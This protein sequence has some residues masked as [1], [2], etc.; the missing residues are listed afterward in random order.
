MEKTKNGPYLPIRSR[1]LISLGFSWA[2]SLQDS[3]E[4]RAFLVV[5]M[6]KNLPAMQETWVWSLS[7]ED[8]LEKGMAT[9]SSILACR[10]TQM[11]EPGGLQSTGSQRVGSNWPICQLSEYSFYKR[12]SLAVHFLYPASYGLDCADV[13]WT[14]FNH[15]GELCF[16]GDGRT[17]W[18]GESG[19]Q[20]AWWRIDSLDHCFWTSSKRETNSLLFCKPQDLGHHFF[21]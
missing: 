13:E 20:M 4:F 5:Q 17:T 10:I 6:V 12:K 15:A 1:T 2:H 14:S 8:P 7:W 9:H 19:P 3:H 16:L 18:R 11:Q 21:F